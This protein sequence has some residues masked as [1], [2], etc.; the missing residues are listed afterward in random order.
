MN[1]NHF[2]VW[3]E[4]R[5]DSTDHTLRNTHKIKH[6]KTQKERK[7]DKKYQRRKIISEDLFLEFYGEAFKEI[8]NKRKKT[9]EAKIKTKKKAEH[10][11]STNKE[12]KSIKERLIDLKNLFDEDLIT[13]EEYEAQRI[14]LISRI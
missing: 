12:T 14:S 11:Y 13:K 1:E 6:T 9:E 5:Q 7:N 10:G 3:K 8:E 2:Y 4:F